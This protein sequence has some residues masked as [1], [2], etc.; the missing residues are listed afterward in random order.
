MFVWDSELLRLHKCMKL[1]FFYNVAPLYHHQSGETVGMSVLRSLAVGRTEVHTGTCY[2]YRYEDE[3]K[4]K[5]T[6]R[7]LCC[8]S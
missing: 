6:R 1:S 8:R 4:N 3:R 5:V 7:F 2:Y